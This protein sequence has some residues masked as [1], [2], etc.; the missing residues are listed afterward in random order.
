[1]SYDLAIKGIKDFKNGEELSSIL[2]QIGASVN[3]AASALIGLEELAKL[4]GTYVS[5]EKSS[6]IINSQKLN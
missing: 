5:D 6:S 2:L 1:M 4:C 3:S